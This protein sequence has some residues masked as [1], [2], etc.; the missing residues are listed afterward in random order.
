MNYSF[1]SILILTLLIYSSVSAQSALVLVGT[2]TSR[3]SEGVY[4]YQFDANTGSLNPLNL[5]KNLENPSFLAI[6][7]NQKF[8]YVVEETANGKVNAF[9]LDEK[10]GLLTLLNSQLVN[11][12]HPCHI[13][14]DKSGRWVM[15]G[16]YSSGNLTI[17][18]IQADGSLGKSIQTIQHEGKSVNIDRQEKA[19][20]H[21]VNIAPN[22][23]DVFVVDLGIDKIMTYQLNA[24]TGQLI[25]GNP[26]FTEVTPGAGPRHFAFHPQQKWAYA[27]L[28][29]NATITAFEYAGDGKLKAFQTITTLPD[30]FKEFN[31]CADIH[32]SADGKYLYGSNRG[33]NSIAVYKIH[34]KTGELKLIQHQSVMGEMPR[35]FAI[36]PS[37]KFLLVANQNTDNITVFKR[38]KKS[39]KLTYTNQSFKV[40]MPVCI[41]FR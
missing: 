31:S 18:P 22:N 11:G 20:V 2:Y 35:N 34:P 16:N 30:D 4:V 36:D 28:E 12:D 8:V 38:N 15:V 21:S 27:I 41:K 39:G 33:H 3:G 40:S 24:Q 26:A 1:F 5:A 37:G 29:L 10:T 14:V 9:S 13:S 7:P 32:I 19:H 23:R 6:S 25:A 17:F